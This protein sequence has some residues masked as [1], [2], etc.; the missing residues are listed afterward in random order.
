MTPPP[1]SHREAFN[2]SSK[3][4]EGL[5][6]MAFTN[7]RQ[8][9]LVQF[10]SLEPLFAWKPELVNHQ[11]LGGHLGPRTGWQCDSLLLMSELKLDFP[12]IHVVSV[13]VA[14][15]GS[16]MLVPHSLLFGTWHFM[17]PLL[18]RVVE[19]LLRYKCIFSDN[20]LHFQIAC[21]L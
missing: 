11:R 20:F 5:I 21:T 7:E 10:Q 8:A 13:V 15:S 18:V 4:L 19:C 6:E 16:I 17:Q 1:W 14:S 12:G 2:H 9:Y 3:E